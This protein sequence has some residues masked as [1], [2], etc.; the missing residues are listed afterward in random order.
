MGLDHPLQHFE[1]VLHGC[2]QAQEAGCRVNESEVQNAPEQGTRSITFLTK[3]E[4]RAV[5]LA[6]LPLAE[7]ALVRPATP[8]GALPALHPPSKA[9]SCPFNG[10]SHWIHV[11]PSIFDALLVLRFIV[12]RPVLSI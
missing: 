10:C 12:E 1:R 9:T 4:L 7:V 3:Q 8:P 5:E 2:L 6:E 11:L